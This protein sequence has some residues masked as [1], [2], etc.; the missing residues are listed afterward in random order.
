MTDSGN[1]KTSY[2]V[3]PLAPVEHQEE[4]DVDAVGDL[5]HGLVITRKRPTTVPQLGFTI[6]MVRWVDVIRF[7]FYR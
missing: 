7:Y 5:D 6:Y 2:K 1:K 3:H 4:H